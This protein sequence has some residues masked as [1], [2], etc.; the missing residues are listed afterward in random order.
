MWVFVMARVSHF[1]TSRG[2]RGPGGCLSG[3]GV[4]LLVLWMMSRMT[5]L[6]WADETRTLDVWAN[7]DTPDEVARARW[8]IW[9]ENWPGCEALAEPR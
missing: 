6:S 7:A 9:S 3:L 2:P 8:N 1:R 4:A 5:L